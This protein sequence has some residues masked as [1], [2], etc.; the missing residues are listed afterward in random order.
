MNPRRMIRIVFVVL[1]FL[2]LATL[3]IAQAPQVPAPPQEKVTFVDKIDVAHIKDFWPDIRSEKDESGRIHIVCAI[4]VV[5][6]N[7]TVYRQYPYVTP[8]ID[9]DKDKV[10]NDGLTQAFNTCRDR[11]L[12]IVND[13]RSYKKALLANTVSAKEK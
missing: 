8:A 13:W 10:V 7:A 9:V 2:V 3:G 11:I 12:E 5:H 1:S 4:T 6:E